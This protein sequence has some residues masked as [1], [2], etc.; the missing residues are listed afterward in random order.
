[1]AKRLLD[2]QVSVPEAIARVLEQ[3]GIEFV[4]GMPGGRTGAIYQALYDHTSTIRCVLVR[5]EG[6]AAVMADVYGRLR[7]RPGVCMGQAAFM[8]TNAGM[9]IVEAHLAGSPV[10][11]LSDLSDGSPFSHHGPYQAGTGDYGTWDARATISGYT[12]RVFVAREPAAAVQDTQIAIKHALTGQPGP[13]AVLY[14]S[15]AL[16]QTVGPNTTPRLYDTKAY[17]ADERPAASTESVANA[18]RLLNQAQQPV[19]IAGN[20][21][22]MSQAQAQLRELAELL[23]V[24]VTTTAAGKGVFPETH[25]LALGVFGNFGLEAANAT[26]AAADLVLAIGTK[27]GPTDTANENPALLDPERQAFLQV[28]IEGLHASWTMPAAQALVGDAQRVLTQ[29]ITAVRSAEF[30]SFDAANRV[31]AAHRTQASFDIASSTSDA[32]PIMPMRVIKE[33]HRSLP[34]DAIITCDAGENRLFMLHHYQTKGTQ[35]YIQP[36][37]VGGMGYAVP[38]A[39]AAK[40]VYPQRPVVAVCG[41]GGFGIAL[42]GMM[43]AREENIPIVAVVF[44]NSMLGWVRHGQ[45]TRLIASKFADYDLAAISRAMG[46]EG[47]RVERPGD[48][49]GAIAQAIASGRPT[50]VDVVTSG[51]PTFRDVQTPLTQ[52]P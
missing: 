7:G 12:K 29:I 42:N 3:A 19:I 47:I 23:G 1:M 26:L 37:G 10:L 39:L 11:V 13:V 52:Y 24:P 14:H 40:L 43:T 45:G 48:L 49:P 41:D 27:L 15:G 50:V 46:C 35:E 38:A 20:G 31:A 8:L 51:D 6:L 33:L 32:V 17:L 18:L 4:F 9:G 2:S 16:T 30:P 5:E 34:D 28:D 21:V 22:R 36:A 44:N 25:P